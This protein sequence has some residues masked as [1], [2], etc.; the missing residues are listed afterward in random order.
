VVVDVVA[1]GGVGL[2]EA[3]ASEN[4]KIYNQNQFALVEEFTY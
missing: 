2:A 1:P 4:P 3:K